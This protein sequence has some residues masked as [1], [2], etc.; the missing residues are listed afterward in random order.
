MTVHR[1]VEKYPTIKAV[2]DDERE[3]FIDLA[4]SRLVQHVRK[5]SLP[6]IMFALKT[7]GRSR[8][9]VE[10]QELAGIPEAPISVILYLPDNQRDGRS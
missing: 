8:G 2:V 7:V 10:R 1:Y 3:K 5:G 6:A 4:E 9:Y